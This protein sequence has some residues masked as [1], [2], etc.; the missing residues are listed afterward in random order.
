MSE[1]F[2]TLSQVTETTTEHGSMDPRCSSLQRPCWLSARSACDGRWPS[3]AA[4]MHVKSAYTME[5]MMLWYSFN[6]R[7]SRNS[8]AMC[9]VWRRHRHM[10][11][12]GAEF[13]SRQPCLHLYAAISAAICFFNV[14]RLRAEVAG[15]N[16][17][18][19]LRNSV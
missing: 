12:C 3:L 13:K 5:W 7:R 15:L 2:E 18:I 9:H 19:L 10:H 1:W 16:Y 6:L 17:C 11:A 4:C 14:L 8:T